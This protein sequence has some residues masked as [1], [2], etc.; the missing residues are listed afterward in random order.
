MQNTSRYL[1]KKKIANQVSFERIAPGNQKYSPWVLQ[2][3]LIVVAF[4][5]KKKKVGRREYFLRRT[6]QRE[7]RWDLWFH[8]TVSH[9]TALRC[10]RD[11]FFS[12]GS[13]TDIGACWCW[14]K[15]VAFSG[16][17]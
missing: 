5:K 14:Q 13:L 8:F 7:F 11:P 3:V 1:K 6:Q 16:S 9:F 17:L 15:S 12:T 2:G 4:K 10:P